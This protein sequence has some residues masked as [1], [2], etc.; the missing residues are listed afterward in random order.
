MCSEI[1]FSES[2]LYIFRAAHTPIIGSTILTV[3]TAVGTIHSRSQIVS[4]TSSQ[5]SLARNSPCQA[6]LG[7]SNRDDLGPT[8]NC[9]NGC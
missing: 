8:T 7:G 2:P 5:R 6:T 1:Y 3:S 9:T 4:V